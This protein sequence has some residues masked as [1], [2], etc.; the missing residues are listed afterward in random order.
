MEA[1]NTL[2]HDIE[3]MCCGKGGGETHN[4]NNFGIYLLL[5]ADVY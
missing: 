2:S 4:L 1:N 3:S 5:N